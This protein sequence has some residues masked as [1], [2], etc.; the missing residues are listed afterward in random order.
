MN[1][2]NR[3]KKLLHLDTYGWIAIASI[4]ICTM[5][6]ILLAISYD[7]V[8]PYLSITKLLIGNPAASFAR[9]LHFWS[10]QAFLVFTILHIYDQFRH[11]SETNITKTGIWF[12]LTLS[13]A[14][15]GYIMI[16]GFILKAD[17]D[18][19]QARRI[20]SV[21]L[22]SVPWLGKLL[23]RTFIGPESN[24]QLLYI[25]HIA[26]A[27]IILFIAIYDHVRTIWVNMRTFLIVLLLTSLVSLLF[28]APLSSLDEAVMKGPWYFVGLQEV[29]HWVSR[30]GWVMAVTFIL[31]FAVFIIPKLAVNRRIIA[32]RILLGLLIVYILLTVVGF[33]F[34]GENWQWQWPW[35]ENSVVKTAFHFEL[36]DFTTPAK[37]TIP[38]VQGRAEACL[39]CHSGMK[40]LSESH[41]EGTSG[42]YSCHLGDPFTLDKKQAH[43]GMELVPGNLS[44][45][46]RTCGT[47]KCHPRISE[48]IQNSMMTTLSGMISVDRFVFGETKSPD[49][50]ATVHDV[51]FSAADRHLRNLC[52]GCHVGNEK[53]KTGP[54]AWLERG[55]GC[56]ACHLT[57]NSAAQKDLVF[58]KRKPK[59]DTTLPTVHPSINL[60]V[61]ND[62]CQSCHSRSGRISMNY[63]G[64][65]E[66]TLKSAPKEGFLKFK[67][68]PD[69]RVFEFVKSD[70]HHQ[71]GL[72]CIDCHSSYELMGDGKQ[73]SHKEEAVKVQCVDCH[74][75]V[76]SGNRMTFADADRETQLVA[77]L[78][79]LKTESVT[80]GFTTHGKQPLVNTFFD[81][82]GQLNLL[83]KLTG[84]ALPMKPQNS[85][86]SEGKAHERL[87][88]N[89]CHTA[90]APQCIGCHNSY[91][92]Q[93][94]GFDMLKNKFTKGS[95]IEYTGTYLSGEPVL[96]INLRQGKTGTIQTMVPGMILTVDKGSF[97]KGGKTIFHRLYAPVS[98]H[99]TQK[100]SRSCKSC[101]T[102]P[103]SLGYGR[104]TLSYSKEGR[105]T[106]RPRFASNPNDGLPEDAWIGFLKEAKGTVATRN[107]IRPFSLEEQKRILTIGACL[108]CHESGSKVIKESL[109]NFDSLIAKRSGKCVLP[110]W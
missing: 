24:W 52:I 84:Q 7:V 30:P 78:R 36:T 26:T 46:S 79:K 18:S 2:L 3:I 10:A 62:K 63:E 74:P 19:Q 59:T 91:E 50:I 42:C 107:G 45:S 73:Y 93:S 66:T 54:P 83:T 14:F 47:S 43:R 48:R 17:A 44:N 33:F 55:G 32:K 64:W 82:S 101:H 97:E 100:E 61:A 86:C 67:T 23:Q 94:V 28:R 57:Y 98:A 60:Q 29:L 80:I 109:G 65:H 12:R 15:L 41:S 58:Q 31:L 69:G 4:L 39:V 95:W 108:T 72:S 38:I 71:K 27:T 9:N 5:S 25:Q 99:T 13:I 8:N 106:F 68:L 1:K 89:A 37:Q 16:S 11:S 102:D 70:I 40:G 81:P 103:L 90:W 105:W 92:K 21:L 87:S 53:L 85:A 110:V 51:G 104:G 56:N 88:C 96:G 75:G 6:G 77:W 22:E 49:G 34:R 35:Q 76:Q 20:L